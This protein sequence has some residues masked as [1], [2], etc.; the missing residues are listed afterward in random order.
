[1]S[2]GAI[3]TMYAEFNGAPPTVKASVSSSVSTRRPSSHDWTHPATSEIP[4]TATAAS[5]VT[6]HLPAR[7]SPRHQPNG[8]FRPCRA[9]DSDDTTSGSPSDRDLTELMTETTNGESIQGSS[10]GTTRLGFVGG[11]PHA[12]TMI[13]RLRCSRCG[14]VFPIHRQWSNRRKNGHVKTVWCVRCKA[15]TQ[16]LEGWKPHP[17]HRR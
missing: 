3:D 1:M 14:S 9:R 4:T 15:R 11:D 8:D 6:S 13:S 12:Q 17:P 16:H 7:V 2:Y 5:L 10:C